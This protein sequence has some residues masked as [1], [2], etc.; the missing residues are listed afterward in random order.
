[1]GVYLS[2]LPNVCW[3]LRAE[4]LWTLSPESA[5]PDGMVIEEDNKAQPGARREVASSEPSCRTRLIA[6]RSVA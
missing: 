2:L 1:M 5:G 6:T 4:T 3:I